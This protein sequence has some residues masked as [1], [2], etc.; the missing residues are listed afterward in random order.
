MGDSLD[1]KFMQ[2]LRRSKQGET[3]GIYTEGKCITLKVESVVPFPNNN[4]KTGKVY[5]TVI[6]DE[7]SPAEDV[8]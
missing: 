1:L 2:R 6:Y 4:M 5:S 7:I 8:E 3:F